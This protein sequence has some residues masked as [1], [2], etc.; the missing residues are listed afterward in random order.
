MEEKM[1]NIKTGYLLAAALAGAFLAGG[2]G[3]EKASPKPPPAPAK[4]KEAVTVLIPSDQKPIA[5]QDGR[6]LQ[7]YEYE[8]MKAVSEKLPDY[9]LTFEAVPKDSVEAKLKAGDA[10][11]AVGGFHRTKER[12]ENFFIPENPTGVSA[13]AVYVRKGAAGD[14][15]N[16]EDAARAGLKI[17][18]LKGMN[19][20]AVHEWNEKHGNILSSVPERNISEEEALKGL[21]EKKW[22]LLIAPDNEGITERA[23]KAGI[24]I[25]PLKEPVRI[26]STYALV[27]KKDTRLVVELAETLG[28]LQ[29]DGTLSKILK[30]WYK[31]DL[32]ALL[33]M[34]KDCCT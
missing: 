10:L 29:K 14:L 4:E 21:S 32:I 16:L 11:L 13:L 5:W 1:R 23:E 24:S 2:C 20:H 22:D 31:E 25:E 33:P 26:H 15:K 19:L 12:E 27:S 28:N 17:A 9:R 8:V 30:K 3:S 7:G 6:E 18:P 34:K